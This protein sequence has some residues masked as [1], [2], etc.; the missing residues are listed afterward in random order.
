M[1]SASLPHPRKL[2]NANGFRED[3]K[4][5]MI[6]NACL[7]EKLHGDEVIAKAARADDQSSWYVGCLIDGKMVNVLEVYPHLTEVKQRKLILD[8]LERLPFCLY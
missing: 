5:I 2:L 3:G 1:G 6:R 7:V 4:M 8:L